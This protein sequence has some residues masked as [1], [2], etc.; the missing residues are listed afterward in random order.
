VTALGNFFTALMSRTP[1]NVSLS[2]PSSGDL[3]NE[4]NGQIV[5]GWAD[6]APAVLPGLNSGDFAIGNGVRLV[7]D[8]AGVVN[9]RHVRGTTFWV[10]VANDVFTLDGLVNQNDANAFTTAASALIGSGGNELVV[11]SR[12]TVGRLGTAHPVINSHMPTTPTSLRS[13]RY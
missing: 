12:P 5:G 11:W 9:G 6:G 3:I 13:R 4:A 2:L 7:W 8:T 10:P 1:N